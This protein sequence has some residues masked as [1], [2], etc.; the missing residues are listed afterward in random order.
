MKK[1]LLAAVLMLS[2]ATL[3]AQT[4][5]TYTLNHPCLLHTQADFDYVKEHIADEPYASALVK[6]KGNSRYCNVNYTPS[7]VEYLARLDANNWAELNWRWENAGIAHLWYSGIHNNYTNFMRDAAA[8]YQLALLYKIEGN[9]KAADAAKRIIT[10]WSTT[11]KGLLRN[12]K[13]EIIDPNEKLIMFQPY[14]MAVAAEM[15]RDYNN[16]QNTD[17]FKAAA[18]WFD[19]SFYGEAHAHLELQ[20]SSGG[21]H[22]WLNW[23]LAAMT[24]ILAIGILCDKQNYI[25]EAIQYYKGGGGGPG[26]IIKGVPYLHPDA[27]SSEILGQGNELGRDQGHNTLCASVLGVFCRMGLAIGDDLFAFDNYRALAFAEYVAKYNLAH[28]DLY[29]DPMQNFPGMRAGSTDADFEYPHASFP[30]AEYT[31]GDKGTMTEPS[32]DSRG[33]VRPG[34]DVWVG[35]ANSRGLRAEYCSRIAKN[36]RPDGGGGH[37][38]S[39]SGGFDQLGFSTLMDYRPFTQT[40]ATGVARFSCVADTWVRQDSPKAS[41]GAT[42]K[43]ELRRLDVKNG[44]GEV[45]GYNYMVGLYGFMLNIPEEQQVRKATLRLVTERVKGADVYV[46]P[47]SNDFDENSAT[48]SGEAAYIEA[49]LRGPEAAVFTASGQQGK[50]IYDSG[51]QAANCSVEAWTNEIDVTD[52]IAS[53][54]SAAKR[55]NFILKED[56]DQVCFFSKDNQGQT[57]AFNNTAS[58]TDIASEVLMPLLIV[59][60]GN[61]QDDDTSAIEVISIEEA[62]CAPEYFTLQG[63]RVER[64]RHG[65]IYIVKQ[66]TNA[67]KVLF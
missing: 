65:C 64:P 52:Y 54:S 28:D 51:I 55:V 22:Y 24:S 26:N 47:Y 16:W 29:P 61:Q 50:A 48:W 30:F 5:T 40:E 2:V 6:L 17:E 21:G 56:G 59:E 13:G 12:N 18:K 60:F 25:A 3:Q 19:D 31:Y 46:Y 66:G 10:A 11:N 42:A 67:S 44:A 39:N 14:Q 27:D 45:A 20:N 8:A 33:Q 7:P 49:A 35:Y 36:T 1:I 4:A 53:L 38:S 23:D 58:A 9:T 43:V 34:W 15:L 62:V 63:I 57:G 37:Y 32:Q 41:N